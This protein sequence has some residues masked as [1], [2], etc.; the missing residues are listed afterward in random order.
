MSK[1]G[2]SC[3]SANEPNPN[4]AYCGNKKLTYYND[5]Y[6]NSY[7]N[8]YGENQGYNKPG[9]CCKNANEPSPNCV[10]CRN[11]A[12]GYYNDQYQNSYAQNQGNNGYNA[13]NQGSDYSYGSQWTQ[14][15]PNAQQ[16]QQGEG[17]TN[18]NTW[19]LLK[20]VLVFGA[21]CYVT[22]QMVNVASELG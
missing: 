22:S 4:C 5:Q 13:Y 16:G 8:N 2:C 17:D 21:G 9:C 18:N 19:S 15:Q 7:Q 3:K 10:Y 20:P 11:K 14:P 12:Q 6:Q 1:P